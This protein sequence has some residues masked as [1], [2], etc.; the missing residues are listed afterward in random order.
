MHIPNSKNPKVIIAVGKSSLAKKSFK[1]YNPFSKK[2]KI[3][4]SFA[5]FFCVY[6]NNLFKKIIELQTQENSEFIRF[7][8]QKFDKKFT[9]SIYKATLN[10]KVVIQLQADN[11]IFGY[12]KYPINEIGIE[13]IKNEINAFKILSKNRALNYEMKNFEF[14]ETPFFILPELEGNIETVSDEDVLK[15]IQP[16]KKGVFKKLQKH[17]RVKQIKEFLKENNFNDELQILENTLLSSKNNYEE[18][19]EHG[20]FAPWNIVKTKDGF[21]AFDFEY[22]TEKGLEYFD[23]IKYHFQIGRLL[24]RKSKE[25][26]Y[27]Y[28]SKKIKIKEIN[29]VF[30]LFLLKEIMVAANQQKKALFEKEMLKFINEK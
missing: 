14:R 4:K 8:N 7:L 29:E 16:F 22:F 25:E 19:Y 30:S 27:N 2:A 9:S 21:S 1:L 3:F 18:V 23:L 20:D 11:K 10:D 17:Y 13:N 24:K 28:V 6:F 26:L 15:I 12:V 5:R